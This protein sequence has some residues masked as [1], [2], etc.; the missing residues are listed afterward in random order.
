MEPL[1]I[2]QQC[3]KVG[4]PIHALKHRGCSGAQL[5][6]HIA[7]RQSVLEQRITGLVCHALEA[8]NQSRFLEQRSDLLQAATVEDIDLNG[9]FV[10]NI[11]RKILQR[12]ALPGGGVAQLEELPVGGT[13][14][15][16]CTPRSC[17]GARF[18]AQGKGRKDGTSSVPGLA[19]SCVG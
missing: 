1:E 17:R 2:Q 10:G 9:G 7:A 5:I 4:H 12:D 18:A 11:L 6:P 13:E 16:T 19:V 14:L 8:K 15:P 3:R